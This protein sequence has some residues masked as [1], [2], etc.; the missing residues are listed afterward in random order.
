MEEIWQR[1]RALLDEEG[2]VEEYEL[3]DDYRSSAPK[4]I[5]PSSAQKSW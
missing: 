2:I 4:T 1:E 3:P 5:R